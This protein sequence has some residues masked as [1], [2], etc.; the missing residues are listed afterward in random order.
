LSKPHPENFHHS[1]H[2]NP[3]ASAGVFSAEFDDKSG[4]HAAQGKE[5]KGNSN[6]LPPISRTGP[7]PAG[8]LHPIIPISLLPA[9][10]TM[11]MPQV[12]AESVLIVLVWKTVHAGAEL[13]RTTNHFQPDS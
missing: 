11:I 1:A 2:W 13:R 12:S 9:S 7:V 3:G 6:D 10:G 8:P 4:D 5:S